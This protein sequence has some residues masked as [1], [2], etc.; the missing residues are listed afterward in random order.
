MGEP[1][2]SPLKKGYDEFHCLMG[3]NAMPFWKKNSFYTV[4][5]LVCLALLGIFTFTDLAISKSLYGNF[6][7]FSHFFEVYGF[8]PSCLLVCGMSAI[9][10]CTNNHTKRTIPRLLGYLFFPLCCAGGFLFAEFIL[11]SQVWKIGYH[12]LFL[13]LFAFL[14]TALLFFAVSKFPAGRLAVYRKG[15]LAA[16]CSLILILLCVELLKNIFGRVR[17]RDMAEP[18]TQFTQWYVING[19][20]S[21]KSFP[22][23]HT[24]NAAAILCLTLTAQKKRTRQLIWGLGILYTIA[25]AV[26]RILAGA[27]F[28]SDVLAGGLIGVFC[29]LLSRKLFRLPS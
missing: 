3:G 16:L 26:S 8:F 17:F 24:A 6:P 4:L 11:Y 25:M 28:A 21:H 13:I 7:A 22:S 2:Y 20:T 29:V 12:P 18:F 27:H 9:A 14:L 15:A 23:G 10:F 1:I 5:L 19:P